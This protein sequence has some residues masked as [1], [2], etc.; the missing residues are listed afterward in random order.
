MGVIDVMHV[1]GVMGMF[2]LNQ[3]PDSY[4]FNHVALLYLLML[5]YYIV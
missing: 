3:N 4:L 2:T 1:M 5:H